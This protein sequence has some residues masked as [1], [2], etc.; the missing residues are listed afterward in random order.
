M[1][2]TYRFHG[3]LA[4]LLRRRWREPQPI[5]LAVTR[6]TSI[7]DQV[8]A[9]GL[10][11][12]EIGRLCCDGRDIDFSHLVRDHQS[13]DIL[14]VTAPWDLSRPTLLRPDRLARPAF[15]VDATLGRLARSLRMAGLNTLYRPE[16]T[17]ADLLHR[18]GRSRRVLLSRNL[19]LLKRGEVVFGRYIRSEEPAAQ[20]R[21]VLSLFGLRELSHPLVR[22]LACNALLQPVAKEAIL[23]RLEPLTIRYYDSFHRCPRCERIY[24]AGS[25][26][27][28]MQTSL[29]NALP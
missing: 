22:C 8:E 4:G 21:E 7:K 24:W 23:D 12:T 20:L 10:P 26:V 9:F 3:D 18:L 14:P 2:A 1:A 6:R 28:R 19:E 17:T 25:H 27:A 5:V 13:F 29:K 15:L 11:H 16:W